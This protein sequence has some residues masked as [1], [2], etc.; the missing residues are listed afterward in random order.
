MKIG[1]DTA[2]Y[3]GAIASLF[4]A[5][6]VARAAST[7]HKIQ[8]PPKNTTDIDPFHAHTSHSGSVNDNA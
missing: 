2:G 7:I 1:K 4:G 5:K 3:V 6:G 8:N